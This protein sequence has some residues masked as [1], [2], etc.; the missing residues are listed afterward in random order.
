VLPVAQQV[1]LFAEDETQPDAECKLQE[2]GGLPVDRS[3]RDPVA[4][5]AFRDAQGR[6]NEELE[7]ERTEQCEPGPFL[8]ETHGYT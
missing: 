5:S 8:P 2:F 1:D 6:E 4:V 7:G 3:D